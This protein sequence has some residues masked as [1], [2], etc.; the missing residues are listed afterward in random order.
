MKYKYS[1]LALILHLLSTQYCISQ[2]G[3]TPPNIEA[4]GDQYYCPLSQIPIVTSFDIVDP[5]DTEIESFNIQISS[6]YSSGIDRLILTGSHPNIVTSWNPTTAKLKLTGVGGA[7][8]LYTDLIAAVK[9][10]VYES[11]SANVSGEK[12][13]SYTI[14]DANYLPSTGH[15]YEYVASSGISWS[16]AKIAAENRSYFGL[17]GYL[18]TILTQDEAQ[19]SGEQAAG[20]GWLGG[21]DEETE[22][23][24]KWV[25]GPEA[26]TV[27]WNGLANGSTPNYANWNTGEPNQFGGN[28]DYVHVTFNVGVPG[29]W[30]DLPNAGLT[31]NYF[32]QGYIVEYGGMPGDPVVDISA[33]TKITIP[34][35]V[36]TIPASR[37]G[38][39][40]LTLEATASIGDVLWYDVPTGGTSIF[41]GTVFNTPSLNTST[42]YYVAVSYNGCLEG[43][44]T[45]VAAVIKEIP[46]IT[47][48]TNGVICDSGTT[49]LAA[50]PSLGTVVWYDVS[51]GG[52]AIA[53]GNS[54]TTPTLSNTTTYYVDA[55]YNGCTTLT[56]TAVTAMV[57]KTVAPTGNSIQT[58]CD[59][60]NATVA[61]LSATGTSIIWYDVASGGTPLNVTDLLTSKTYY[62]TQT[63]LGC[64]SVNRLAVD[65]TVYETVVP[66]LSTDIPILSAC[67]TD[68]DGDD[69]NGFTEFDLTQ[70]EAVI[71][72]GSLA[73]SFDVNYYTDAAYIN[74]IPNPSTFVNTLQGGQTIYVRI[75][76]NQDTTCFTDTSFEI[77]VDALPTVQPSIVYKNCD[78]DG[79][80][81]GF[82]DFNLEGVNDIITNGNSTN[83]EFTYYLDPT[84]AASKTGGIGAYPFNNATASMV[85][86]RVENTAGCYR[87]AEVNLE[88][89]TTAIPQNYMQEL[90]FC[91]D[92]AIADGLHE[93]DL[94]SVNQQFIDQ[95]PSGQ[96]LSVHYYRNLSDAQ[97][98]LNEISDQANYLSEVP[99]SQVLYVRVESEDNGDCF[100]IGPHLTLTVR[101]RPEFEID[102]SDVF[103]LDNG[104]ITL[105]TYNPNGSFTYEW[106]NAN[107]T[108]VGNDE[109]LTI[110]TAGTYTVVATS[111]YGCQS[112]PVS[113]E[114]VESGIANITKDDVTI[115]ELSDNNSITIDTSNLGIG[116]YE[117]A[118]DNM[119]GPYQD[120]PIFNNVGAGMHTI[121]VQD[122]KGCGIASLEVF[123]LGFPKYFTPNGDG[124]NDTWNIKGLSNAFSQN[125]KIYIFDRYGKLIKQL[126]PRGDGWDGNFNGARLNASDYWFVAEL[127]ETNGN[128]RSYKGHFSLVR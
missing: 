50:H 96:N 123:V 128:R 48:T 113:F 93:F 47:S 53:T 108:V 115:V 87:V 90:E 56:R 24:W 61:N 63:E 21:T 99:F 97:L 45:P 101:Q 88:V 46:T 100:G 17:Q 7:E 28:E 76:N 112:F 58:F 109:Y 127:F 74:Q 107:G 122:K 121:Y 2:T 20:V 62:A 114:V 38:N 1:L 27:F 77:Q 71:L 30:N 67:D 36:D 52:T 9:D 43:K 72:N 126:N 12:Y 89:S 23:V 18:A 80:P 120:D 118:L 85:Y 33:S 10:V 41:T 104:P 19:L 86:V 65:V 13:F 25:T 68:A 64:E 51:T 102:Q 4:T 78:E 66:P 59:I 5:D 57:Q 32:P 6:G 73:S 91:D 11:S 31:G 26:G 39:G 70:R 44:R 98:E 110:N 16:D 124:Y 83:L 125:S 82:T 34:E 54:F 95:F 35:I 84:D 42:T 81:D 14:G 103:C 111:T 49:T 92:D 75:N 106:M 15:Y 3:N 37:C 79:N 40:T 8:M 22:G 55:T 119:S 69:T 94:S 117:F 116:D 60:D 105:S 29:S